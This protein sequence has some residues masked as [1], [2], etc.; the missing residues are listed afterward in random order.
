MTR[1]KT[2]KRKSVKFKRRLST[3]KRRWAEMTLAHAEAERN[4][5]TVT[6]ENNKSGI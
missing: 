3:P 6:E 4:T 2:I 1:K 5:K